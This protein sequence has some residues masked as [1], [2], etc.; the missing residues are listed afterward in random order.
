[1]T[2]RLSEAAKLGFTRC[3]IPKGSRRE[4]VDGIE[5]IRLGTVVEAAGVAL[6]R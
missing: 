2:A 1:V 6:A 4:E 3:L 5:V